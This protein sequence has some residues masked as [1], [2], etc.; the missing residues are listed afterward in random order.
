MGSC[1]FWS[2]RLKVKTN[3]ISE[4][5]INLFVVWIQYLVFTLKASVSFR[6]HL[7]HMISETDDTDWFHLISHCLGNQEKK[8]LLIYMMMIYV[9]QK[10]LKFWK[11]SLEGTKHWKT[12]ILAMVQKHSSWE[13]IDMNSYTSV[14]FAHWFLL[15][16]YTQD[17]IHYHYLRS[18]GYIHKCPLISCILV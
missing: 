18:K 1:G 15:G 12:E 11:T 10:L 14:G 7:L 4:N 6:M 8:D 9:F 5:I 2:Q 17:Y 3:C 13:N 16:S